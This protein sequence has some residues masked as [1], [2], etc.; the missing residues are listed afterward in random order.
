MTFARIRSSSRRVS[1]TSAAE[2]ALEILVDC[3]AEM[4][5]Q[6]AVNGLDSIKRRAVL[7]GERGRKQGLQAIGDSGDGG[8]NDYRL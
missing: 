6:F 5:R 3:D 8:V 2:K 4:L 7:T 1:P